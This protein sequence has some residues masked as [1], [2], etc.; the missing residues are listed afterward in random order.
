MKHYFNLQLKLI[1]RTIQDA[2]ISPWIV[3][4]ISPILFIVIFEYLFTVT[5]YA[6]YLIASIAISLASKLSINNRNE[7]LQITFTHQ[8]YRLLRIIENCIIS[9][10]FSTYLLFKSEYSISIGILVLNILLSLW[11]NKNTFNKTIP[12]PFSSKSFE[13]IVGFRN[14]YI[15]HILPIFFL[16]KSVQEENINLGLFAYLIHVLLVIQYYSKPEGEYI[17]WNYAYS[18]KKF[19]LHKLT[20]AWLNTSLLNLPIIAFLVYFNTT[21]WLIVISF[22]LIGLMYISYIILLKYYAFPKEMGV[23]QGI[24]LLI[25]IL[26]P[27]IILLTLPYQ[28]IESSKRLK[29]IL[30]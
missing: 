1:Y 23:S 11:I 14:S 3:I 7:F 29:A 22:H 5:E 4:T 24:M 28:F 27:P 25:T 10:P 20:L 30:K 6:S 26:L 13:F 2:G 12:T 18:T 16:L 9:I 15:I 19:L 8:R 21:N 17:V